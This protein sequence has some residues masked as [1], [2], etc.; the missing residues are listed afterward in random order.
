VVEELA[1]NADAARE[2]YLAAAHE[3][4]TEGTPAHGYEMLAW[5][6]LGHRPRGMN[7]AHKLE[8]MARGELETPLWFKWFYGPSVLKFN[9]GLVQLA[10]GRIDEARQMWRRMLEEEPDARWVRLH[11]DMPE[12]LV[13]MMSRLP[14]YPQD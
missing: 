1:G 4:H 6:A 7:I 11:L 2:H 12:R 10:K 3:L 13:Q 8:Q 14:G 9:H 5:L